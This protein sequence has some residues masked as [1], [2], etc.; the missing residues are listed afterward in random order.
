M[1][2]QFFI[3]Q[4]VEKKNA[5]E[6]RYNGRIIASSIFGWDGEKPLTSENGTEHMYRSYLIEKQDGKR[7]FVCP[8][9]D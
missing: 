9:M 2:A 6:S 3:N 5:I 7:E 8:D 1:D 4:E